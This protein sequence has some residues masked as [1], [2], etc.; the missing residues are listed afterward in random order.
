MLVVTGFYFEISF[1]NHI[2]HCVTLFKYSD[3]TDRCFLIK[4]I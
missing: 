3:S 2:L 4:S 1:F